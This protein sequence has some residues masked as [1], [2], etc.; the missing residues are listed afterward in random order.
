MLVDRRRPTCDVQRGASSTRQRRPAQLRR[1][2][3][4]SLARGGEL[5]CSRAPGGRRDWCLTA[6]RTRRWSRRSSTSYSGASGPADATRTGSSGRYASDV[7]APAPLSGPASSA[8]P[9]MVEVRH[10]V[11]RRFEAVR[12]LTVQF[13]VGDHSVLV[14][15][16]D[17]HAAAGWVGVQ[18]RV[19]IAVRDMSG[20]PAAEAAPAAGAECRVRRFAPMYGRDVRLGSPIRGGVSPLPGSISP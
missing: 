8:W 6:P 5:A 20:L 7:A 10:L 2:R 3:T 12:E 16:A 19:R 4:R 15:A 13:Q 18:R 9:S 11:E 14:R 1:W 17:D